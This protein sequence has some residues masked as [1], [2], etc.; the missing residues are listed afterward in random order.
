M[1]YKS[2][3]SNKYMGATFAGQVN[4]AS[5]SEAMDLAR[6]LQRTVN[7]ALERIY[8]RNVEKQKDEAKTKINQ[9]FL[10]G[11]KSDQIQ[12]EILEGKHPELSGRYV[13]KTVSYHTGRQEAVDAIANIE[14]NKDKY[15]H[16]ET[17]LPAFY[18]E[19]LPSFAD[20]DGSYTLGFAAVFNQYKAKDAIADAEVRAKY[21]KEQKINQGSKIISAVPT[22][23]VWDTVNSLNVPLPPEEGDTKP[24]QFY[25]NEELN[26]VVIQHAGNLL[27]EA[28]STDEIDRAIKILSTDRGIKKDGTKL[29]SLIDTNRSDVSTLIGKLN[30]KRVTL[31]TQERINNDYKE[32]QEIKSIFSDAFADNE[33]GTPKTHEQ[34]MKYRESLEK[35]GEPKLLTAFDNVMKSN[36][37]AET[38]PAKV[39][40]FL[41]EILSGGFTDQTEMIDAFSK[42]N[43]PT[44]E[45]TKALTY[46]EKWNTNN[47][48]GVKPIHQSS[49]TYSQSMT[50][51]KAAVQGNFTRNGILSSNGYTAVFNATNYMIK[52][53]NDFED[54]FELENKRK[55]NNVER[56]Q[57]I[58]NLGKYVIDTYKGG[59][60]DPKTLTVTQQEEKAKEDELKR[61]ETMKLYEDLGVTKLLDN[62]NKSLEQGG[63]VKPQMTSDDTSFFKSRAT[64][65]KE[66]DTAKVVPALQ[67]YLTQSFG[68]QFTP[69]MYKAMTNQDVEA[70]VSNVAKSLKLDQ[71]LVKQALKNIVTGK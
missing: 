58:Q 62:L 51:I 6:T 61:Q 14:A 29:G 19:Y 38:D 43:I 49:S 10:E 18:K 39:D 27:N 28:T 44:A 47:N 34:K 52:E 21:A 36:R 17:N 63:F 1:A 30:R 25:S 55:P 20:R 35:Y 56:Q 60:I 66:F 54:R 16:R 65:R 53:I 24:R 15:D 3:V 22:A 23:E 45:L 71:T 33:D 32:K 41:I 7:P 59:A 64:E 37:F 31:E 67:E 8:D 57:F 46:W 68:V 42:R 11:K 26:Q 9:L 12:S 70:M 4:A 5:D 50:Q 40:G 48:K 69:E 13:E 2:R